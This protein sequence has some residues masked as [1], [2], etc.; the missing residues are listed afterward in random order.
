MRE[1]SEVER[2]SMMA[3]QTED[4]E[5]KK[6]REEEKKRLIARL[7]YTLSCFSFERGKIWLLAGWPG[8]K[9]KGEKKNN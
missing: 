9:R 4:G 1:I 8:E 5:R 2:E 7:P 3:S 6:D